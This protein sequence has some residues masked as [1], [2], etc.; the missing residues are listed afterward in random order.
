MKGSHR[1]VLGGAVLLIICF[2]SIM[3]WLSAMSRP[4][5]RA[6]HRALLAACR[7]MIDRRDSLQGTRE[8]REVVIYSQHIGSQIPS[9]VRQLKPVR[10][11][12]SNDRATICVWPYPR[13]YVCAFRIGAEESG[14][15]KLIDGLWY[16]DGSVSSE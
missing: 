12:L 4:I 10:I 9:V 8:G 15:K 11:I 3:T 16:Y 7:D 1:L 5:Y 6:D 2:T 14:T 13:I